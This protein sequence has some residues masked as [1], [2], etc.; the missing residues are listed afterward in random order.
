MQLRAQIS[1]FCKNIISLALLVT[2]F[3]ATASAQTPSFATAVSYATG[4]SP[5]GVDSADFNEDGNIDIVVAD[6]GSDN[7]TLF[8]GNGDGTL[9]TGVTISLPSSFNPY[10]VTAVD[11]N[12]DEHTDLVAV[13]SGS[14]GIGVKLGNGDGTFQSTVIYA[15]GTIAV[16]GTAGDFNN[17]G[18]TDYAVAGSFSG[19]VDIFPGNGDGTFGTAQQNTL[20]V[21]WSQIRTINADG[22]NGSDIAMTPD[23]GNHI[24]VALNNGSG[25]F[26]SGTDY[27]TGNSPYFL[28]AGDLNSDDISDIITGNAN[29]D[30]ISVFIGNGDGTYAAKVDYG[31]GDAPLGSYVADFNDDGFNDVVVANRDTDD[32]Q[33]YAGDGTGVLSSAANF[34]VAGPGPVLVIASDLN[35][36]GLPDLV[37]T[38]NSN[39]ISVLINTFPIPEIDIAGNAISIPSGSTST[40]LGN[41]TDFGSA[42]SGTGDVT[43]SFNIANSG[44]AS[45]TIS[46]SPRVVLSG[47]NAADFS[48]IT[49]PDPSVAA[50]ANSAF[51]IRFAPSAT[52]VRNATVTVQ[53][54]DPSERSYTFAIKGTGIAV[55]TAPTLTSTS[56]ASGADDN[57]PKVIGSADSG[58]TVTLYG[59]SNCSG[60]VLGSGPAA[61]F[62]STGIS[63]SVA[64]NTTTTIYGNIT[65]AFDNVSACS[66]SFVSYVESTTVPKTIR[67]KGPK[68]KVVISNGKN[69]RRVR[70]KFGSDTP[71]ATFLCQHNKGAYKACSSPMRYKLRPGRHIIRV[72]AVANGVEDPT[73]ATWR[74]VVEKD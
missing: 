48:V 13:R 33:I 62:N 69:K 60:S 74:L 67:R 25:V 26:A 16:Y 12:D 34:A 11:L 24:T 61:T 20:S 22:V 49:Q 1:T 19:D 54:N 71:G 44:S 8:L 27:V 40:S 56:P 3:S 59:N 73:P 52:G 36:D 17:D 63:I 41:N 66:T 15:G 31:A 64:D 23:S 2:G 18:K 47:A 14:A 28:S 4:L 30:T 68:D 32:L 29:S 21:S 51:A 5:N 55:P 65:D 39:D 42:L 37:S 70:V 35:N 45:L 10:W 7:L 50:S 46:G 6:S 43:K 53:N 38:S 58:S 57:S 9:Q 72:K